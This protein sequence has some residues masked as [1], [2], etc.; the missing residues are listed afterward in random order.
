MGNAFFFHLFL[1]M[2]SLSFFAVTEATPPPSSRGGCTDQL[3]LFSPCLSYVSS[4]PNNL[5]ETPSTECCNSF[6]SSFAP[7]SL[8]FFYLLRGNHTLGFPLNSTR[9]LSLSSLC[10]SPPPAIS[11]LDFLCRE[12]PIL[13]LLDSADI[14]VNPNNFSVTGSVSNGSGGKTVPGKGNEAGT[15]LYFPSSNSTT[16]TPSDDARDFFEFWLLCQFI[17]IIFRMPPLFNLNILH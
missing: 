10:L 7:N 1:L 9:L 4:L 3:T 15:T 6:S 13:P 11:F 17:A 14:L 2:L 5:T 16:S 12:S 8:C